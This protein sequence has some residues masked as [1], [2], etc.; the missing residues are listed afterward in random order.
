MLMA[1]ANDRGLLARAVFALPIALGLACGLG[2]GASPPAPT[3]ARAVLEAALDAWKGGESPAALTGAAA[4]IKVG[5]AKWQEGFKLTKYE[6]EGEPRP[7]GF[8][9]Q[10]TVALW[11]EGPK[12]QPVRESARYTVTTQPAR[13]VIRAPF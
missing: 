1:S 9:L 2:C 6:V 13:T 8:D 4:G 3:E 7:A 5:E 11:M 12:G 10:F